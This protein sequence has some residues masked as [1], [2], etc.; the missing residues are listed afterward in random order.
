MNWTFDWNEWFMIVTSVIAFSIILL[1]RKQFQTV[2]FII[3]WIY[4]ITFVESIDYALAGSPFRVYYCAD[5]LTYEPAAALIH[6]FLYPAFSFIFLYFYDRWDIK[7]KNLI[8]YI[9][10]W[11]AFS[12]LFEWINIK[13]GVFHYTG[14][15]L[16]YSIPVY[17]ISSLLLIR[18]FHFTKRQLHRPIPHLE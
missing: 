17:P 5:N 11:D 18:L 10:L 9:L 12:I 8:I 15:E 1:I 16:Y 14:W 6:I 13:N 2:V 7:G 3:I 4:S